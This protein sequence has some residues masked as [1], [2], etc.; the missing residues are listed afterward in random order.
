MEAIKV[1]AESTQV[2]ITWA[3]SIIGGSIATILGTSYLSPQ[4]KRFRMVY[5]LFIPGWALLSISIY[6]G[7]LVSRRYI[8]A[9]FVAPEQLSDIVRAMNADYE[10]QQWTLFAAIVVF[11]IWLISYLVWWI[12]FRPSAN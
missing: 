7:D 4:I 10:M 5:L 12:F 8:A 11:I 6:Y 2:H 3:L 1:I 9:G